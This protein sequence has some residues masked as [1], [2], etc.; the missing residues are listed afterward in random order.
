MSGDGLS[1]IATQRGVSFDGLVVHSDIPSWLFLKGLQLRMYSATP[2][3][4]RERIS[5]RFKSKRSVQGFLSI[6]D[7]VTN[8]FH[9]PAV[10]Y[11]DV[12]AEAFAARA[13]IPVAR[14]TA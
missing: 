10:D 9:F 3:K 6:H 11:R 14:L 2:A 4:R 12:R 13:K 8:L 1:C 7:E 5:K